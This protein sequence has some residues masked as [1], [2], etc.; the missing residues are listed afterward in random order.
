MGAATQEV[1]TQ[2]NKSSKIHYRIGSKV[3]ELRSEEVQEAPE[4]RIRRQRES[5]IDM[6]GEEDTLT[7]KR[8]GFDFFP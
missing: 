3:M 1:F 5:T 6:G 8:L 7:I 4:K 2:G